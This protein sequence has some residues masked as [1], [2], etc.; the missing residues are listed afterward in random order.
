MNC[1]LH[2]YAAWF[3]L[4]RKNIPSQ[5]RTQAHGLAGGTKRGR[6]PVMVVFDAKFLFLLIPALAVFFL[7]WVLWNLLQQGKQ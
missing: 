3:P 1:I 2:P 4:D 5:K 7:L 6:F